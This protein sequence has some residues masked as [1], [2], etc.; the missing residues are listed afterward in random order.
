MED[1]TEGAAL[2]VGRAI[3]DHLC[4]AIKSSISSIFENRKDKG[5]PAVS[6]EAP[7]RSLALQVSSCTTHSKMML[8]QGKNLEGEDVQKRD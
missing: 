5:A 4:V 3:S 8:C 7:S 2:P 1:V 6:K